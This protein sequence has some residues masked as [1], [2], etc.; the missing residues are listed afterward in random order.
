MVARSGAGGP[1]RFIGDD[2]YRSSFKEDLGSTLDLNN[3]STG[4]DVEKLVADIRSQIS[5]SATAEES[6]Q[7]TVRTEVLRKLKEYS[8]L[9]V[10]GVYPASEERLRTVFEALLFPGRVEAV[11]S[12]V[13]SHDSLPLGITQLGVAVVGYNGTSGTFSQRLFRKELSTED[14]NPVQAAMECIR[15]RHERSGMG[16]RDM[17]SKLARRGLRDYAERAILLDKAQAEWRIGQGNPCSQELLSGSGYPRLLMASLEMLSRL[18]GG[19]KKFVFV[20]HALEERGY[21]TLGHALR[22]GEYAIIQTLESDS[23]YFVERWSYPDEQLRD[24]AL[25]FVRKYCRDILIGLFRSS[26][27]APPSLFFAHR[28]H[29]HVAAHIVMADSLIHPKRGFPMLLEVADSSCRGVFG[30]DSFQGLVQDAY[31]RAGGK[32][33][34][35][36][37]RHWR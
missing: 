18:I 19:H 1:D 8:K 5:H 29:V 21:L 30:T 3:W 13:A 25:E 26:E 32:Y 28:E 2:D 23:A 17:L 12:V 4:L 34:Y 16:R 31:T 27:H 11:T 37:E 15:E 35:F 7:K 24:K 36:N 10:A 14:E 20:P 9:D 33:E 6:I 22:A